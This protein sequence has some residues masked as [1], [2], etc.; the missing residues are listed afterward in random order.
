MAQRCFAG[1]AR[2]VITARPTRA[3][4]I[5]TLRSRS[6]QAVIEVLVNGAMRAQ[7][8]KLT[9]AERRAVAEFVTGKTVGGDVTGAATGRCQ[10]SDAASGASPTLEK[11]DKLD[12]IFLS[13]LQEFR[14]RY[15]VSYAP[16][17]VAHDG[18]HE[19][20]VRVKHSGT[21]KAR[22]GYQS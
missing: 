8:A 9:G 15:L 16:R 20:D 4:A 19:L 1:R 2:R 14:Q 21:V 13:I 3:P 5:D 10:K 17:G 22:P 7:G 11:T 18:W 12:A 6:P